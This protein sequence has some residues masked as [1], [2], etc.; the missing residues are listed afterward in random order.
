MQATRDQG[1]GA[2]TGPVDGLSLASRGQPSTHPLSALVAVT[3]APLGPVA[4]PWAVLHLRR[5]FAVARLAWY[6]GRQMAR[7]NLAMSRRIWTPRMPLRSGMVVLPTRSAARAGWPRSGCSPRWWWTRNRSMSTG[8]AVSCS[9]TSCRSTTAS[10]GTG[11]S[12][13]AWSAVTTVYAIACLAEL[14][15]A[16]ALLVRVAL[17][18]T[19]SDRIVALSTVVGNYSR[20]DS[21]SEAD[22]TRRS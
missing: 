9:T 18:P 10:T 4:G 6:V 17:G 8:T 19:V 2:G 1:T 11:R 14:I 22:V 3:L 12:K 21:D 5:A 16:A 13:S 20:T 7:A 15:I